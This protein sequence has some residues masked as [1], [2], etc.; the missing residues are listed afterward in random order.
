M[1][2]CLLCC[3]VY[4]GNFRAHLCSSCVRI[5]WYEVICY[6]CGLIAGYIETN[7]CCYSCDKEQEIQSETKEKE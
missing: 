4:D 3:K 1:S 7:Y 2:V 5:K 6:R